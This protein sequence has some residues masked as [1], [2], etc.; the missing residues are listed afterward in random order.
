MRVVNEVYEDTK[1]TVT[2]ST[3]RGEITASAI[4]SADDVANGLQSDRAGF[5]IALQKC[6]IEYARRLARDMKQRSI[7]AN[8]LTNT[9]IE[10]FYA[11]HPSNKYLDFMEGYDAML[12]NAEMA[13]Y[14]IEK[15]AEEYRN[16]YIEM[17]D[18]FNG[19]VDMIQQVETED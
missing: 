4:C 19:Y 5:E 12:A 13:C 3:P 8:M 11:V 7:G 6:R 9:L 17:R 10:Q 14:N 15:L 18:N 1:T 2:I 16:K